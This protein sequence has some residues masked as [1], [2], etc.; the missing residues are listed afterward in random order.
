MKQNQSICLVFVSLQ[1]LRKR[2]VHL[3][4]FCFKS[5]SS[6]VFCC[7]QKLNVR[8]V[9]ASKFMSLF[10]TIGK[11]LGYDRCKTKLKELLHLK[12]YV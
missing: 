11:S 3:Q 7:T 8:E 12:F 2:L 5:V 9:L 6:C 4:A 1:M 10:F